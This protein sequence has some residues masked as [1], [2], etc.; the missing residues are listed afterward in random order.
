[1]LFVH[2]DE[3]QLDAVANLHMKSFDNKKFAITGGGFECSQF[4]KFK[5]QYV[6]SANLCCNKICRNYNNNKRWFDS[7][8]FSLFTK[9][10]M[11][12]ASQHVD[13]LFKKFF[14]NKITYS[15]FLILLK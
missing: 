4:P 9:A 6:K 11:T 5:V 3:S 12:K 8:F 2:L 13:K 10:N 14:I 1:M 15:R 7:L